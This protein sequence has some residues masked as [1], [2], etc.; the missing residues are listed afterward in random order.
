MAPKHE[1]IYVNFY[2]DGS[3]ARKMAPAFPETQVG[4]KTAATKQKKTIIYIDPIALCSLLVAAVM[5]VMMAVGITRFQEAQAEARM[6]ENYLNQLTEENE[7]LT[8]QY[9]EGLNLEEVEKTAVALGMVPKDQVQSIPIR[10]E[11]QPE[12][13][14]APTLWEQVMAFLTNLFA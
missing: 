10:L 13:E 9:Q 14:N 7:R 2:T 11:T 8:A 6:M 1:I 12:I 4:K 3:A 5:L